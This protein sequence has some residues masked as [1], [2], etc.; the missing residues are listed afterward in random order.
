MFTTWEGE[1]KFIKAPSLHLVGRDRRGFKQGERG[2]GGGKPICAINS[3]ALQ[4]NTSG[5]EGAVLGERTG[6]EPGAGLALSPSSS[7]AAA[8]PGQAVPTGC[9]HS[10]PGKSGS[11]QQRKF[12]LVLFS[13]RAGDKKSP[14][15]LRGE[16]R[17]R[18]NR[19]NRKP[20]QADFFFFFLRH[21]PPSQSVRGLPG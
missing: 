10:S 14:S 9:L 2:R 15:I 11:L 3:R 13:S 5:Q 20:L 4:F 7:G 16:K 17:Q 8:G 1:S 19:T 12:P 18:P 21:T 6:E